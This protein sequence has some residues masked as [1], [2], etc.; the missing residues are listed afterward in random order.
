MY[1]EKGVEMA[2]AELPD[3]IILDIGLPDTDGYQVLRRI[4]D[5]SDVPVIILTVRGEEMDK[6]RGLELG[7]DDYIVKPFLPGEFLARVRAVIRRMHTTE[8][9]SVT[10]GKPFI[11]GRLRIDFSSEEVIIGDKPLK[12]SPREYDLLKLLMT[13]EGNVISNEVLL[14]SINDAGENLSVEFL[15]RLVER[16]KEKVEGEVDGFIMTH[17]EGGKGYKFINP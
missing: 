5:F 14:E 17:D 1:G 4:R 13:N 11:S 6:I 12:L 9:T 8:K 3:I 10:G 16:L 2:Q 7:S 15:R